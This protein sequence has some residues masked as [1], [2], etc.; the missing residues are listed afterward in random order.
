[1]HLD[2]RDRRS[3]GIAKGGQHEHKKVNRL[4]NAGERIDA[5]Q[6]NHTGQADC[7]TS[8]GLRVANRLIALEEVG[9]QHS[10]DWHGGNH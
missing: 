8:Q 9:D 10:E 3:H 2:V 4:V 7:Q 6:Q 5:D 1:M